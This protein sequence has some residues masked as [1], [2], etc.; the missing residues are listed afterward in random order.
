MKISS[1]LTAE[2]GSL[3]ITLIVESDYDEDCVR[4]LERNSGSIAMVSG[5]GCYV[6]TIPLPL[7]KTFS[8]FG[9]V[10]PLASNG[11]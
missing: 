11:K 9:G 10:T 2:E 7:P 4:E 5:P 8:G 3:L 1:Q 6:L